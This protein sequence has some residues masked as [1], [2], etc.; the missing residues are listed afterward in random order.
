MKGKGHVRGQGT[1][2][3]PGRRVADVQKLEADLKQAEEAL[4]ESEFC[5]RAPVDASPHGVVIGHTPPPRLLFVNPSFAGLVGYSPEDLTSLDPEGVEALLHPLDRDLVLQ[6]WGERLDG[7]SPPSQYKFRLIRKDGAV[8]WVDACASRVEY[9]GKGAVQ[10]VLADVTESRRKDAQPRRLY[11]DFHEVEEQTAELR[12]LN[13]QLSSDTEQRK[14]EEQALAT[15]GRVL[16][17]RVTAERV[18]GYFPLTD[19]GRF[20]LKNVS[21]Q[22][23]VFAV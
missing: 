19:L 10:A 1:L 20:K 4:R 2:A 18:R 13:E 3:G 15:G 22:V 23:E 8:I 6:R 12:R 16:L 11:E 5:Y 17:S 21:E 14:E 9:G 7:K